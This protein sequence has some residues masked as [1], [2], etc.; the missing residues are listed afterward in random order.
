MFFPS[1]FILKGQGNFI[2]LRIVCSLAAMVIFWSTYLWYS[3]GKLLSTQ[4]L[5]V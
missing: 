3:K 5:R 2:V 4:E 1:L